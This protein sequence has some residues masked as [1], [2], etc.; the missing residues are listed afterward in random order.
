[1]NWVA[2]SGFLL[3][4]NLQTNPGVKQVTN[5]AERAGRVPVSEEERAAEIIPVLVLGT[6]PTALGVIRCL[7]RRSI[8]AYCITPSAEL[9]RSSRWFRSLPSRFGIVRQPEHLVPCLKRLPLHRAVLMPCS[10]DWSLAVSRLPNDLDERFLKSMPDPEALSIAV[11]KERFRERLVRLD[12][13][14]PRTLPIHEIEDFKQVSDFESGRWFLKPCD[15]QSFHYRYG[16]KAFR[17]NS[18]ADAQTRFAQIRRDGF[19]VLLQEYVPGPSSNHFYV[20]GLVDRRGQVRGWF[21]R[22]RVRMYPPDFGNSSYMITLR[23]DTVVP[24]IESMKS[25]LQSLCYRGLFSAEFKQDVI[26]GKFKLLEMNARPW[27]YIEVPARCGVDLAFMAYA[28]ALGRDLPRTT[29]Y[30]VGASFVTPYFDISACVLAHRQGKLSYREWLTSWWQAEQV[31]F[32]RD[33]P[34][35]TVNSLVQLSKNKLARMLRRND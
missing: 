14:H 6:G 22:R 31:F 15:S 3:L 32:S 1:L 19:E 21:V 8:P 28:D 34:L 17:V 10:D 12:I 4:S 13:P 25:L 7:G 23:Q 27:W 11:N 16:T 26:D 24:A 2:I 20:E 5:Q 18:I 33:D 29:A 9:V 30:R 35:P